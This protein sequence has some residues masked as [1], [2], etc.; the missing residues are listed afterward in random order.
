MKRLMMASLFAGVAG[1]A[2]AEVDEPWRFQ[3]TPY[4]WGAGL[5]G[6]VQPDS[7]LPSV[8]F[9]K[10]FGDILENLDVAFFLN[11]TARKGRFVLF[12]DAT[13]ARVTEDHTFTIPALPLTVPVE[14][15]ITQASATFAAGYS[16]VN[17][18]E[19]VLDVLGGGRLWHVEGDVDVD[20]NLPSPLPTAV[21]ESL[22]WVDPIVGARARL[23]L[24]PD[25]SVIGYADVGGFGAGSE[26]TWQAVGTVNYRIND[27]FYLSAGYRHMAFEYDDDGIDLEVELSGP[28]LGA[29]VR[30]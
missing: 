1:A 28:L 4:A 8:E 23:Q 25:W 20:I 21:S 29:T 7:R 19:F 24:A 9:E 13:Y 6:E 30:F 15:G 5:S 3:L 22:T 18:P 27:R 17:R 12:G 26:S 10:S 11:G 16:V 14:V 2:Q